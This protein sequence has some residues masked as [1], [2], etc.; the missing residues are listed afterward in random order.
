MELFTSEALLAELCGKTPA[1]AV[2]AL[3]PDFAHTPSDKGRAI[4]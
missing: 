2:R 1:T 4:R 3:L